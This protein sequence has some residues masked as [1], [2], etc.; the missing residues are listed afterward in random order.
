[1]SGSNVVVVALGSVILSSLLLDSIS[2]PA[3]EVITECICWGLILLGGRAYLSLNSISLQPFKKSGLGIVA[4]GV[5]LLCLSCS[6]EKIVW[7]TVSNFEMPCVA[8]IH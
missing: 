4:F 5:T 2:C 1:M 3:Q 7:S 6:I 8:S